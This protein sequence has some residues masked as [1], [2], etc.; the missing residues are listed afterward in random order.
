MHSLDPPL[1]LLGLLLRHERRS[2]AISLIP[3]RIILP[4]HA[5]YHRNSQLHRQITNEGTQ[6]HHV[7]EGNSPFYGHNTAASSPHRRPFHDTSHISCS[8]CWRCDS[9]HC[10][11]RG[12]FQT[13]ARRPDAEA[14]ASTGG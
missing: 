9:A 4:S 10:D 6:S 3:L 8:V 2:K 11:A 1:I 5:F 7:P 14:R 13:A 12:D